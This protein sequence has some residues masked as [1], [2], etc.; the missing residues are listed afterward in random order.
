MVMFIETKLFTNWWRNISPT[1]LTGSYKPLL[2]QTRRQALSSLA[3]AVYVNSGGESLD[4]GNVADLGSS[5]TS[6]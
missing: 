3:L 4:V 5:N 6:R 2:H 1:I